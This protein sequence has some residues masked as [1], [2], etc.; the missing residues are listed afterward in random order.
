M[1]DK[2]QALKKAAKKE[3]KVTETCVCNMEW[4]GTHGD[5]WSDCICYT[6]ES[7]SSAK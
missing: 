6:E 2:K 7:N 3:K 5:E 1:K 4:R